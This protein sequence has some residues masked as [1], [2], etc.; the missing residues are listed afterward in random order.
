MLHL[1]DIQ[2]RTAFQR[3]TKSAIKTL[4]AGGRPPVL[5]VNGR[6][7]VVPDARAYERLLELADRAEAL[8]GIQRGLADASAPKVKPLAS[9]VDEIRRRGRTRPRD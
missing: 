3:S 5:T 2:P 8:E 1:S 4:E 7:A 9:A 6:S